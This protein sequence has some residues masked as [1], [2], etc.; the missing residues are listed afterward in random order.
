MWVNYSAVP[1]GVIRQGII[2]VMI[3]QTPCLFGFEFMSCV[4]C[5]TTTLSHGE[6]TEKLL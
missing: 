6:G 3:S 5:L 2:P 1:A 4:G